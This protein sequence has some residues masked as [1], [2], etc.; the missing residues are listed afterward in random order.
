MRFL[1]AMI[2]CWALGYAMAEVAINPIGRWGLA[3]ISTVVITFLASVFICK[4][5]GVG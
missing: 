5:L 4:K 2:L 1:A 3:M